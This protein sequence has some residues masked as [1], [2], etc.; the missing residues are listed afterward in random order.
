MATI[1]DVAKLAG[2]S[3][4]TVSHVINN[5]A[6]VKPETRSAV[7]EAIRTLNYRPNPH[8][9]SLVT[10]STGMLSVVRTSRVLAGINA[11]SFDS[12]IETTFFSDVLE[13]V[14][15]VANQAG[16]QVMV[17]VLDNAQGQPDDALNEPPFLSGKADGLLL[18]GGLLTKRLLER[19]IQINM[20][21]A[22]CGARSDL[23]DYTDID[24]EAGI[25]KATEYLISLGHARIAFINGPD[26]SQ[27][28]RRKLLGYR[29]ALAASGIPL[30]ASLVR[31][32][33]FSA[34][35]GYGATAS[36]LT[37]HTGFTAIIAGTDRIAIGALRYLY[38]QSIHCPRDCS[39]IGFGD[40][41]LAEHA[42]PSLTTVSMRCE[43]MG[44]MVCSMLLLRIQDPAGQQ[45]KRILRPEL[46][47]R[48][49]TAAIVGAS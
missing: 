9:R 31:A 29:S 1:R 10:N 15:S 24:S 40:G 20:P 21:V 2:V 37:E 39:V 43:E 47:L 16:Y 28:S 19:L 25:Y 4:A 30:D 26:E 33:D 5:S 11:K 45:A 12:T 34:R 8:A 22:L 27:A 41:L 49:S 42:I 7:Q 18:V 44:A 46:I 14:E 36:L 13:G 3:T 32:S 17:S 38:T 48:E 6:V 23:L 35:G